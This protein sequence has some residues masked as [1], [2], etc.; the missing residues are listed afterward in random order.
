MA[1]P[2]SDNDDDI[3][4]PDYYSILNLRKEANDD[5]IKAAYRRMC[6]MYHPD[7]HM[8]P[9]NKQTADV[10]FTKVTKAYEVLSCPQ[11]RMIY[12]IYGQKGLDAGWEVIERRR[13]PQEIREEYER[14]QR[15]ADERRIEKSTNPKGSVTLQI[16]ATD[17]FS[18]DQDDDPYYQDEQSWL[19]SIEIRGMS[20][21]QSIE[22]PLT[23]SNTVVLAG[24]LQHTNGNGTGNVNCALKRVFSHQS[25]GEVEL[26]AG[27]GG[28]LRLKAFRNLDKKRFC[29]VTLNSTLKQQRLSAGL[30]A[31]V[32]SQLSEQT[33]GY[34]S[35]MGG[36][37]SSSMTSTL[38]KNTQRY[39]LMGQLQL[40]VPN[41]F[42]VLSYTHK[43][44]TET[45]VKGVIKI[46]P[47]GLMLEYG[48][49]HQ[50]TALSY[51][52]MTMSI[53]QSSGVTLKLK[54][55]R[56]TQTFNF[57]II[58]CEVF[59]PAAI[60]YGTIA[61]LIT[62]FTVKALI[63][64]PMVLEQREKDIQETREK[65]AQLIAEKKKEAESAVQLMLTSYEQIVESEQEKHGFVIVEA[66]Y[67]KFI[68]KHRKTEQ[69][70]PYV[71][72]VTIP[73]Q[74]L[75][76]E[77]KLLVSDSSKSQLSGFYDPCVGEEKLLK[78]TY[79][80]RGNVHEAIFKDEEAVRCPKQSHIISTKVS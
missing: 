7:K 65:H 8:D 41:S 20:F 51:V 80:F 79:E 1:D 34:L 52:G 43:F 28:N 61:P 16:D 78:I 42:G 27:N 60:F 17:I 31:M 66:W 47:L 6:V 4:Q 37:K 44:G 18:S 50:I 30:Q 63:I 58:L 71:I 19:P 57:P 69:S 29:T 2:D 67:G 3:D 22:A 5:E 15:E 21:D 76:K 10:I 73:I 35:W 53:G 48:C 70:T 11:T 13:S 36:H 64:A 23:R 75:V 38:T 77:S 55:H 14:L 74:C 45:K 72:N 12:D 54:V 40:G 32:A 39:N 33:M 49:E 59:S 26:S 62:F 46:G 9:K 56:H 68:S 24:Q 25:W